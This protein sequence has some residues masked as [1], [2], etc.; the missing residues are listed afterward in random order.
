MN[1]LIIGAGAVGRGLLGVRLLE[2]G[3]AVTFMEDNAEILNR[4]KCGYYP[5]KSM[6]DSPAQWY[7]PV[8]LYAG[9]LDG[10]VFVSVRVE[11]LPAVA[12]W[13]LSQPRETENVVVCENSPNAAGQLKKLVGNRFNCVNAI[14]EAVIPE[15]P[16]YWKDID[17]TLTYTDPSGQLLIDYAAWYGEKVAGLGYI[18][19]FDLAWD[20]KWYCHCAIHFIVG[21]L[22]QKA[23]Y[24]YVH[25]AVRDRAIADKLN[26]L[27][28]EIARAGLAKWG[29]AEP[30]RERAHQE[31]RAL[32]STARPDTCERVMRD[33]ERKL[34]PGE[35]VLGLLEFV[36][37]KNEVIEEA[38]EWAMQSL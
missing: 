26:K 11:N 33:A 3:H 34:Q 14:V 36:G 32:S 23:G 15:M 20:L 5:V 17:P 28:I 10:T 13:L 12:E 16:S 7:G 4:L 38:I 22:G 29:D 18:K 31:V 35:R 6:L 27:Y 8:G 25:E 1:A 37:G 24:K 30:F 9:V 19:E 2:A 21:A